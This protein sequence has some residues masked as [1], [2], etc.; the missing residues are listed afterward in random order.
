ML[1]F[2]KTGHC[3]AE[4]RHIF[5]TERPTGRYLAEQIQ[6]RLSTCIEAYIK[7]GPKAQKEE[8]RQAVLV[9]SQQK[10]YN[11]VMV[12]CLLSRYSEWQDCKERGVSHKS[13]AAALAEKKKKR[14][15]KGKPERTNKSKNGFKYKLKLEYI[16]IKGVHGPQGTKKLAR[17]LPN[18][19]NSTVLSLMLEKIQC[20]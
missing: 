9:S 15:G 17:L 12:Q 1:N 2:M 18:K 11:E 3:M 6:A 19:V 20:R 8:K 14:K 10:E 4:M 16:P 13:A 7:G 5:S